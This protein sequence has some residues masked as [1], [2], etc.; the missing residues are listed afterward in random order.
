MTIDPN[1]RQSYAEEY[2]AGIDREIGA[3]VLL[4]AQYI[5]RN[6]RRAVGFID[7]GTVWTLATAID[8]G[9]DGL[10]GTGD[11]QGPITVHY[12]SGTAAASL[13]LTNPP[14]ARRHYD[15]LQIIASR[16]ARGRWSAEA[17]YTWTRERGTFDNESGSNTA[18]SDLGQYGNF[19]LPDRSLYTGTVSTND[20]P[21]DVKILGTYTMCC[22]I[23]VSGI[24]RYLSGR[25]WSREINVNP[26][27]HLLS[28]GVERTG[29]RRLE[30]TFN[31]ADVRVEKM[32]QI[33]GSRIG[34]YADVF[35]VNNRGAALGIER[36]SG[37]ASAF[38]SR[39]ATHARFG[40]DSDWRFDEFAT[41][42]FTKKQSARSTVSDWSS[43]RKEQSRH[44]VDPELH[45]VSCCAPPR[46]GDRKLRSI[47]A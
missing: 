40:L 36:R 30:P 23:R 2:L 33:H 44:V 8:P 14:N 27:T 31:D 37:P 18:F 38:R 4:R 42:F 11:D 10:S 19:T 16:R 47:R 25:P 34:A 20:R 24:Y 9:P 13:L 3:G 32:F 21:H 35:N 22:G 28:I 26:L 45:F 15:G 7:T 43:K 12:D 1:V 29:A 39:G 5:R 6:F 41:E 46:V 17:S